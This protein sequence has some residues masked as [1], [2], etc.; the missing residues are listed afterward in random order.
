MNAR[1]RAGL[2]ACGVLLAAGVFAVVLPARAEDSFS[3]AGIAL[4]ELL[5]R[6][7]TAQGTLAKGAYHVVQRG[8]AGGETTL[9]E[10]VFDSDGF[11]TTATTGDIVSK[12]GSFRGQYWNRNPNG[13]VQLESGSFSQHDPIAIAVR[14]IGA[15]SSGAKLLG[16][17]STAPADYVVEVTPRDG[18]DEKRYYDRETYLL[19]KT[20]VRDYDGHLRTAN[21]DDYRKV[22]GRMIPFTQTFHSDF[23]KEP[24]RYD[25]VSYQ[26]VPKSSVNL[27][28]PP[29]TPLFSLG[30]RDSVTIP[31]DFTDRGIIVRMNVGGRG[32]DLLLDSG[33]S[34]IVLNASV[35]TELGLALHDKRAESMGGTFVM[36]DARVND[37][38]IGPLHANTAAISVA[39]VADYVNPLE[40]AV[41]LLGCDFIAS[42]ALQVDFEKKSLTLYANPPPALEANG[43]TQVPIA[44]D[45]CVPLAK[46]TFSGAPGEF[47]L[48]LGSYDTVLYGHYFSQFGTSTAPAHGDPV[49]NEGSYIGGD[50]VR[51][52]EYRMKTMG[53]GNLLFADAVVSVSLNKRVQ[54]RDYDGLI[55][56]TTLSSFSIL[57][58]YAHSRVYLKPTP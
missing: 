40:R 52:Q 18:L 27:A 57:F 11:E 47:I 3:P 16:V 7:E 36:S 56:R 19:R 9:E 34:S 44:L 20:E 25:T 46:V 45:R 6:A 55:G 21:Y 26:T 29:S 2:R 35:A 32:L 33:S 15:E 28:V 50:L 14:N 30:G 13:F 43:W 53:I 39:P 24:R 54:A 51:F 41:G 49:I 37:V 22:F 12:W 4:G 5:H 10:T 31:A 42:G 38:S 23:S 17:S 48:D 1:R 8:L 58:D